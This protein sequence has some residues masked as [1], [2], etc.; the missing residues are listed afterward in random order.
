MGRPRRLRIAAA[1]GAALLDPGQAPAG[2]PEA[3]VAGAWELALE[4]S[5]RRCR[6][7]LGLEPGGIGHILR[8]PAG[9]RRAFPFL[10]S[11]GGWDVPGH[12]RLR[13]LDVLGG[14]GL[15]FKEEAADTLVARTANG[16]LYRIERP[17][18][19][20]HPVEAVRLPPPIPI[21]VPQVTPIDPAKAPPFASLPGTYLIDRYAERE[22]CRIAL[23]TG[24]GQDGRYPA[25]LLEGCRDLGLSAFAPVAWRYEGGRLTLTSRRGHEVTL[26]SERPGHWRRDPEVGATLV[27]RKADP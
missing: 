4:G 21:G 16:E 1:L 2:N 23:A 24:S 15:D 20:E 12:G 13:L 6:L 25:I 11:V 10:N 26:V 27:L 3:A 8:F 18:R 5:H 14:P 19:A 9:C 22:V 17:E 7:S